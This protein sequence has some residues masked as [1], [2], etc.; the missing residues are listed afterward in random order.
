MAAFG[1]PSDAAGRSHFF[2]A[3]IVIGAIWAFAVVTF[4]VCEAMRDIRHD[5]E[6]QALF[7]RFGIAP[8]S[9][10]SGTGAGVQ[11]AQTVHAI[12]QVSS[13]RWLAKVFEKLFGPRALQHGM[14]KLAAN[15]RRFAEKNAKLDP[16]PF[17]I[18]FWS[19]H[20]YVASIP[21]S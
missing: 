15:Y 16:D 7:Q 8:Y 4:L 19:L 13:R 6:M 18:S 21:S 2:V 12:G 1:P 10:V 14:I 11:R 3:A 17:L 20:P 5:Q 9:A